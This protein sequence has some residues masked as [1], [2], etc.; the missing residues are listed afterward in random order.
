MSLFYSLLALFVITFEYIIIRIK[1]KKKSKKG[2]EKKKINNFYIFDIAG[3]V[4]LVN[5]IE[6]SS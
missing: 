3:V 5:H 2:F 6:P 1:K 4:A